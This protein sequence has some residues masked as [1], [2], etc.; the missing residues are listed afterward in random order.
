MNKAVIMARGLGTRMKKDSNS[1]D[2]SEAQASIAQTGIKALIPIDRPFLDYV[3]HALAEG[4]YTE[5]CLIIG[6][7]HDAIRDY[8][9][10]EVTTNRLQISFAIQEEPLGTA[11]AVL[12]AE[13]FAQGEHFIVIN[14]DNY[15][16]IEAYKQLRLIETAGLA[17]FEFEA[18]VSKGN[19]PADRLTAFAVVDSD[20]KGNMKKIVEKP[21]MAQLAEMDKPYY[22]SMNCWRFGPSIFEACK[23][24]KSSLR[25][26]YELPDAVEYSRHTLGETYALL[27]IADA[28]LDM[29][30]QDDIASVTKKLKGTPVSL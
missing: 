28:V 1:A 30:N 2:M 21:S 18:M 8:Y 11:N 25:G 26:E 3:L 24:I 12:A 13:S 16:P 27:K 5:V 19:I 10:K 14:S 9:G 17:G 23:N 4:G 20:S 15:Y 7:E 6:P 29:S 22:I